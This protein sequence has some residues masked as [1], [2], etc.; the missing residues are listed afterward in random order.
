MSSLMSRRAVVFCGNRRE[1]LWTM[2][3]APILQVP[4]GVRL[5]TV[6]LRPVNGIVWFVD[7]I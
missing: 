6:V 7:L 3:F 4:A 5:I 1:F 2:R